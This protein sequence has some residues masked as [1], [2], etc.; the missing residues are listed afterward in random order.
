MDHAILITQSMQNDFVKPLGR[1][2]KIPN[3][4]HIGYEESLR[5]FGSDPS[6]GPVG[7]F[8]QWA[9]AQDVD[10]LSIIHIRDWHSV[11]DGEQKDHLDLFNHHCIADTEGAEFAIPLPGDREVIIIDSPSLNDFIDNRLTELLDTY[12]NQKVHVGIMGVWTDAK[13]SYLA[14]EIVTRYPQFDVAICSALVASSSRSHH[15]L[16]IDQLQRILGLRIIHSVGKFVNY[17]SAG[18]VDLPIKVLDDRPELITNGELD[19]TDRTLVKFLFRDCIEVSLRLVSGGYSGSKVLSCS[20]IDIYGH[21]QVPHVLK[22]GDEEAIARE[23]VAFERIESVLGNNAPSIAGFAD[24]GEKGAIKYRYASMGGKE[25]RTFK[26]IYNE[27]PDEAILQVL[28]IV[29][30]NQLGKLYRAATREQVNLLDYYGIKPQYADRIKEKIQLL[31]IEDSNSDTIKVIDGISCYNPIRF[32][33]QDLPEIDFRANRSHY[34][35][36]VHG[37]L[38]GANIIQDANDNIW[39]IDFYHTARGHILKD[40]IKLENDILY[41]YTSIENE[42]DLKEFILFIDTLLEHVDLAKTMQIGSTLFS[43]PIIKKASRIITHLRSY[44]PELIKTDRNN[45]QVLIA[46]LRYAGH[47]LSFIESNHYQKLGALYTMGKLSELINRKLRAAGPLR[48]N[49]LPVEYTPVGSMSLTILP[50]RKDKSR[51]LT[52][53]IKQL[54]Q[55]NISHI[56]TLVTMDELEEYGVSNLIEE[57]LVHGIIGY[58]VPILDQGV[59]PIEDMQYVINWLDANLEDGGNI[60][61]HCVGGLGRSGLVAACYLVSKGLSAE[62]AINVIRDSRSPRAV[63]SKIQERMVHEFEAS[64]KAQKMHNDPSLRLEHTKSV[65]LNSIQIIEQMRIRQDD[66]VDVVSMK[67]MIMDRLHSYFDVVSQV[68][69]DNIITDEELEKMLKMEDEIHSVALQQAKQDDTITKQE[70][71]L[72]LNLRKILNEFLTLGK[73]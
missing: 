14:Y 44:Y 11:D 20:S 27:D 36:Y 34:I 72:L 64:V 6:E 61:I 16:A 52:D 13:V 67:T 30:K 35:S 5:L 40:L 71:Q 41:I 38:N 21:E 73:M 25:S 26:Q 66:P 42:I 9:N 12:K 39:L 17:L 3:Q 57:Y 22:I 15:I 37:D 18:I 69:E 59:I 46:K 58:H 31:D 28:D 63:E 47:T 10:N 48:L 19:V 45:I 2:D 33:E 68:L 56:L 54:S 60:L 55:A 29:F 51:D 4:L 62:K 50:G 53:D 70:E 43:N 7:L 24:L 23:R 65:L 32:Y 1:Y 49:Y 8:M